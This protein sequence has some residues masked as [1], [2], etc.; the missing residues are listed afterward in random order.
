[1][2][3]KCLKLINQIQKAHITSLVINS[4]GAD[5][6]MHTAQNKTMSRSQAYYSLWPAHL[7]YN[8]H[9][10]MLV[11]SLITCKLI[12]E[13]CKHKNFTLCMML[14]NNLEHLVSLQYGELQD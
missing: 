13:H 8:Q 4:L 7:T 5:S 14:T 9:T 6:Y 2:K 1:M 3:E 10:D 11:K 12:D